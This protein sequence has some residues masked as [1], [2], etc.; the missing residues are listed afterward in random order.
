MS[1][2]IF[3]SVMSSYKKVS[4]WLIFIEVLGICNGLNGPKILLNPESGEILLFWIFSR[5]SNDSKS[6]FVMFRSCCLGYD[7]KFNV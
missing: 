3:E 1:Q 7:I 5:R 6:F 2:A 4:I